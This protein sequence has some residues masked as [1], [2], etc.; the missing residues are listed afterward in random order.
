V[1]SLTFTMG[2]SYYRSPGNSTAKFGS[3]G[4]SNISICQTQL[5]S[6]LK[7]AY[8]VFGIAFLVR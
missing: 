7:Q 4:L 6:S 2:K 8:Q 1:P 5:S 3:F